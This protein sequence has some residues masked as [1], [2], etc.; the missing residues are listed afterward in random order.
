MTEPKTEP[1][2]EPSNLSHVRQFAVALVAEIRNLQTAAADDPDVAAAGRAAEEC[3]A[4]LEAY[5]SRSTASGNQEGKGYNT[6]P[7]PN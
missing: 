1:K 2:T 6:P 7:Y 4:R 3:A 5:A